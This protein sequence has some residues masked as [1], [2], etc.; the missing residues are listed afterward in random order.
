MSRRP[1]G[2]MGVSM[3]QPAHSAA[4]QPKLITQPL[5]AGPGA[6]VQTQ[7]QPQ[8]AP[9]VFAR[10]GPD[11]FSQSCVDLACNLLG[12]V[13][14]RRLP[15]GKLLKGIIVETESY[16]GGEDRCSHSYK[17]KRTKRNAPM[18]MAPGT[19]YVYHIYG[20][21]YC[22]N[23]SSG[24]ELTKTYVFRQWSMDMKMVDFPFP[25]ISV[26]IMNPSYVYRNYSSTVRLWVEPIASEQRL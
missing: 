23:I 14:T 26:K 20:K 18:F 15:D 19:T 25:Y 6:V 2:A 5:M 21:Y 16:L 13:L 9:T 10:L 1:G 7:Q 12:K 17:N 8:Q 3:E 22:F 24:G 11:F 4:K